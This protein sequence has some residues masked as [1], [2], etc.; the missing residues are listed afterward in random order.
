MK[1]L[2]SIVNNPSVRRASGP[3]AHLAARRYM[4][5]GKTLDLKLGMAL[6]RDKRVP[7]M[8]KMSALMV[9]ILAMFAVNLLEL[10]IE[11]VIAVLLP[12]FGIPLEMAFN[13]MET[14]VGSVLVAALVLPH[15]AP[16][17]LVQEIR[18][19]REPVLIPVEPPVSPARKR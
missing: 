18:E 9:G 11:A 10:P 16:K 4:G 12:V 6:Y 19:E 15:V 7:V 2:K 14:M 13:G 8:A 17:Q 5:E 3:L 1:N